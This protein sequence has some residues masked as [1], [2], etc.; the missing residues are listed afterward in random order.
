MDEPPVTALRQPAAKRSRSE[1]STPG[2]VQQEPKVIKGKKGAE[3]TPLVRLRNRV[4]HRRTHG[5]KSVSVTTQSPTINSRTHHHPSL[6]TPWS[7]A[8]P[9]DNSRVRHQA[10]SNQKAEK[11]NND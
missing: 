7:R 9:A 11:E 4:P 6:A 5:S 10:Q 3:D 1:G 8:E 2:L